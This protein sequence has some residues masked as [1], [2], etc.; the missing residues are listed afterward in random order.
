M[1]KSAQAFR[2]IREVADWLD[3]AAHVLRFWE[4]KFPQIKPVKRAGG[5]RY[6]RPADMELVGG[7][8]VLLHDRGLTIRG[9]QK[10][11]SDEGL[12]A[13]TA[14]SPSVDTFISDGD[15]VEQSPSDAWVEDANAEASTPAESAPEA[16]A[17]DELVAAENAA[18]PQD[19]EVAQEDGTQE[20]LTPEEDAPEVIDFP[21]RTPANTPAPSDTSATAADAPSSPKQDTPTPPPSA[22]TL[23]SDPAEGHLGTLAML[24]RRAPAQIATIAPQIVALS[25]LRDRMAQPPGAR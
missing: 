11:I 18:P 8:K 1:A 14:L 20:A 4:S 22:A 13:V 12:A 17:S 15:V 2:T 19:A 9:V 6:Y 21:Q 23:Q 3:V 10:M 24:S 5:R 7:I 25:Q 16:P